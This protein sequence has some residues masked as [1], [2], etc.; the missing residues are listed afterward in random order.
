MYVQFKYPDAAECLNA[1]SAPHDWGRTLCGEGKAHG[2]TYDL[3]YIQSYPAIQ[4]DTALNAMVRKSAVSAVGASNVFDAPM[5]TASEDFSYYKQ[6]APECFLTLGVGNGPANH[7]PKFNID[8][9]AL[10]NGVKTQV[11]I[12][13][14]Y[15][16]Q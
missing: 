12:I 14:D 15:L 4:N 8:E 3:D 7:N 2:E 6:V 10:Q 11:Q 9:K 16:N 1:F 13:L 5:M